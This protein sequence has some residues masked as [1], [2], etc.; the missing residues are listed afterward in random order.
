LDASQDHRKDSICVPLGAGTVALTQ[1]PCEHLERKRLPG[2]RLLDLLPVVARS[3]SRQRLELPVQLG[4][5]DGI[6]ILLI[7]SILSHA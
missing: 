3:R 7:V 4:T 1:T 5:S 2:R 6:G